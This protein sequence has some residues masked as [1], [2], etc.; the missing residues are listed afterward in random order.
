MTQ[1]RSFMVLPALPE[2]LRPLRDLAYNLWWTWN[3]DAFELFRRMD[4]DLWRELRHNPVAMLAQMR[5]ERLDRLAGDPAYIASLR[6]VLEAMEMYSEQPT[7]FDKHYGDRP[8]GTIAYFSAEFGLHE[9]LP[10]Y[11]G[12]LGTLAGDHLKSA[13]DLGLPLVGV[14]LL[15]RQ[16]YFHQY[17]TQDGYQFEDYPELNF[18]QLPITPVRDKMGQHLTIRVDIGGHDVTACVW[19]VMVGRVVLYLLDANIPHNRPEDREITGRLYGGDQEMRIRQEILLGIGGQR[20]L[21]A[22]GIDPSVCHMNE[23]HSAFLAIERIHERMR[24]NNLS[25]EEAR[26]VVATGTVFTTHTPVP[27]G[28]DTFPVALVTRYLT[29]YCN[30][31]GINIQRLLELGRINAADT[32]EPFSMAVLALRLSH[33]SNGVSQL[34]GEVSRKMFSAVYPGVPVNE[35]PI[36][37]ITNGVH[38]QSWLS[39][40]VAHLFDQYLGP[41]WADDPLNQSVWRRVDLIPDAELWRSHERLRERLV[42]FCRRRLKLQLIARGAPPAEID[43]AD[44]ILDPEALTLVFARRFATYKRATLLMRDVDRLT[45]ILTD[46]DRPVQL[47]I[48]GKAHPKDE[49]GKELIKRLIQVAKRPNLRTRLVFIEDY[50]M[51]ITRSLVWGV[52]VWIN[53]PI[54]L[55]EASGTSGMKVTPNGGLNMS[56]LD[57]WWPEAFDSTNGWAIG[58]RRIYGNQDYQDF[59]ESASFYDLL[60]KEIV[61]MFYDR[62]PDDLP[63]RWIAMMKSSMQSC[64]PVFSTSRMVREYAERFYL[65]AAERWH[66]F[67]Q[68][69]YQITRDVAAWRRKV[70]ERWDDVQINS[71]EADLPEVAMVGN[72]LPVKAQVRL[73]SLDPK[74]VSVELYY[75]P[76]DARGLITLGSS[77]P[78]HCEGKNGSADSYNYTGVIPCEYSGHYGYALRILPHHPEMAARYHVGLVRWG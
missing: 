30:M 64:C 35:V 4:L 56:V 77:S 49:A 28:I 57:G 18:S 50:D 9:C 5:Q 51:S 16:G 45:K 66:R 74:E 33:L 43:A 7:W 36:T 76:L 63:R 14:G 53:T 38:V 44:E 37:S 2:P 25:F 20:T 27:A 21:A 1:V 39:S 32:S 29:G 23:G 15:Y 17:L 69:G 12:G 67:T 10:I 47:I 78:L 24:D 65:P 60:E 40:E 22:L 68:D 54:K 48:A 72:Q 11:S 31:L 70:I 34:H 71:V 52:D 59:M 73:G 46:A 6:R 42:A 41:Q 26:E 13:S 61:P 8:V 3:P 75:G 62:G 19:K 55:H 58:D